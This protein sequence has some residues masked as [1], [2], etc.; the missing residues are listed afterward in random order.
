MAAAR[1]SARAWLDAQA[2]RA[3]A[4]PGEHLF[5]QQVQRARIAL[6]PAGR[7]DEARAVAVALEL[8]R[9]QVDRPPRV[10]LDDGQAQAQHLP[11]EPGVGQRRLALAQAAALGE[12]E[13]GQAA[14]LRLGEAGRV[15]VREH[16]GAVAVVVVVRDHHAGLVQRGGPAQFAARLACRAALRMRLDAGVQ[17]VGELRDAR[18]LRRIDHEAALQFE[19]RGVAHVVCARRVLSG[20]AALG[21]VEDH[22]LAQRA[23]GRLQRVDVEMRGEGVEQAQA[24]GDD[25]APV[26]AQAGQVEAVDVPCAQAARDAPAQALRRDRAVGAAAGLQQLRDGAHGAARSE[27]FV[28]VR[29]RERD[30]RLLEFGAGGDLCLLEGALGQVAIGEV[31]QRQAHAADL[32]RLRAQRPARAADDHLGRAPADVDDEARHRR[33]LQA[34]HAGEDQARFLAARDDLDGIAQRR[35]RASEEGVAIARLAQRLRRH[36]AHL[37]HVVA[38]QALGEAGQAGEAAPCRLLGQH[39][40][41]VEARAQ[42]HGFL[43]VVDA[44][45]AARHDLAD[46]EAKAVRTHVDRRQVV[47]PARRLAAGKGRWKHRVHRRIVGSIGARSAARGGRP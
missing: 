19:H 4:L 35:L 39:A 21:K 26:V 29:A 5:L 40:A 47:R 10:A 32:E 43:Q 41:R 46:L 7:V 20:D 22:A 42:A 16:V 33:G 13:V 12:H 28:P 3:A 1:R 18:R 25:L 6:G 15:D 31:A 37:E 36:R 38:A 30:Q 23:V 34:C 14:L 9:V 2:Q 27:R 44:P 24:A 11:G 8:Q 45:V 17:V